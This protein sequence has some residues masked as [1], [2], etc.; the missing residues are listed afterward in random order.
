[1]GFTDAGV[2]L[3]KA[4]FSRVPFLPNLWRNPAAWG[5]APFGNPALSPRQLFPEADF[6]ISVLFGCLTRLADCSAKRAFVFAADARQDGAA[7]ALWGWSSSHLNFPIIWDS[8][9]KILPRD[10]AVPVCALDEVGGIS[11]LLHLRDDRILLC[12]M[13]QQRILCLPH[14][15]NGALARV[16]DEGERNLGRDSGFTR[17]IDCIPLERICPPWS[18]DGD[19]GFSPDDLFQRK[20]RLRRTGNLL[21]PRDRRLSRFAG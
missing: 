11:I 15:L 17:K 6:S 10:Q 16:A 12:K 4:L 14:D 18:P 8:R 1:M 9:K 21:G 7:F 13:H 5:L 2:F 19:Q 3:K 20:T